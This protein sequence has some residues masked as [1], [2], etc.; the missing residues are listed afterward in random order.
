M[1]FKKGTFDRHLMPKPFR[2]FS[3]VSALHSI[4]EIDLNALKESGKR[5]ILLDVDNT[6][7]PWKS[8]DISESTR[9]WVDRAKSLGFHFCV[10]SNTRHPDRLVKICE[11]LQIEFIRDKFKPSPRMFHLAIEKFQVSATE[12]I[13]VGDQ[14]LTDIWGANRANIDAIWVRKIAKK[15]F[16]GTRLVSRNIEFFVG[17]VLYRYFQSSAVDSE[18]RPGFFGHEIVRQIA[19]FLLVGLSSFI[20][21]AGIFSILMFAIKIGSHPLGEV[22]GQYL[23]SQFPNIFHS[24][25]SI[26]DPSVP[27]F[28]V[29]STCLAILNGYYWNSKWTFNHTSATEYGPL[30]RRYFAINLVGLVLST[31]ITTGLNQLLPGHSKASLAVSVIC[32]TAVVAVWNFGGSRFYVFRKSS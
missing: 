24:P 1:N 23:V 8:Y 18:H 31:S 4:E 5:L 9:A 21:D 15:E 10:L 20:I 26:S 22:F 3:P 7:L 2:R 14:L 29:P 6:L 11:D 25:A 17:L 30:L 27:F 28:K 13:M 19:K 32:A 16:V 12:S